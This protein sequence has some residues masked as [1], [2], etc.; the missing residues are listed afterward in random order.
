ML[1]LYSYVITQ[2]FPNTDIIL[3][4]DTLM[5]SFDVMIFNR[6]NYVSKQLS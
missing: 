1:T 5:R 6:E 3:V 2:L 4:S